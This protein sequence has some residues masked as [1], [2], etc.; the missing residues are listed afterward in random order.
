VNRSLLNNFLEEILTFLKSEIGEL[1]VVVMPDFFLDRLISLNYDVKDFSEALGSVAERK[2]GSI[3]GIKQTELRGGNAI[4]TASVLAALDIKVTPIVC[5]SKFGLQL[6]TF[7]LK[8][9]AVDFSHIKI[10]DKLSITT[11]IELTTENGKVNIMLRDVGT[12]AN[13]RPRDLNKD[14]FKAIEKADY[15]CVFNWAGTRK[16]GTELA[17][18]VFR[19]VKTNGKGKT[20]YDTADPIPNR[21]K[22]PE[23]VKNVL[24]GKHVDI[25]SVNENEAICYALQLCSEIEKFRK[26]LKFEELAKESARILASHLSARVDL[27]TTTFSATFTKKGETVVS[28][29][30]VPVLRATGAGD[31]W[32]AG[33]ILGDAYKLSDDNRLTLAN[34]V[35]AYYVSNPKGAHPTRKQ[36]MKFCDKLKQKTT[37]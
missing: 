28:A 37:S 12:L 32:N 24:Q 25:L 5:T 15:V 2:G 9:L 34:M 11:A 35:A 17:K 23:L 30:E 8:S 21:R 20:Y 7:Y 10:F 14:D 36:L 31:A 33:N 27:H 29:F 4:N 18:T 13:F 22:I 26:R 19:H 16:F 6:I 3:D 1:N